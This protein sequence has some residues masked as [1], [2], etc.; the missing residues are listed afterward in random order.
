MTAEQEPAAGAERQPSSEQPVEVTGDHPPDDQGWVL[1]EGSF[2]KASSATDLTTGGED[3]GSFKGGQP[4][5][6]DEG[7]EPQTA[8]F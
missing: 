2:F 1:H 7:G 4:T 5:Q 6:A 3:V 8:G